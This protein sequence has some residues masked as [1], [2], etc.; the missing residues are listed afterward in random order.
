MTGPTK[1]YTRWLIGLIIFYLVAFSLFSV[2]KY[3]NF[4]YNALD[5]GIFNQVFFNSAQGRLFDFTIHPHSYLGDHLGFILVLL[6]PIYWLWQNPITLLILQT[7]FIG[8]TAWPIFLIAKKWLQPK[9]ALLISG[10]FLLSHFTH[11]INLF[12]FHLISL[13][14]PILFFLF[15]FYLTNKFTPF[16]IFTLLGL[17]VR[18]DVALIFIAFAILALVEKRKLKWKLFPSIAGL[19][20][21]FLSYQLT[22]YF[23]GYSSY[24]FL[25]YFAWLGDTP[26]QMLINFFANPLTTLAHLGS[27]G[28]IILIIGLFLP[29]LFIP[30]IKAKYLILSLPHLLIFILAGFNK[31]SNLST[32][33]LVFLTFGFWLAFI[34][35]LPY[36][37]KSKFVFWR[38]LGEEKILLTTV[39]LATTIYSAVF[40]GPAWSMIS[41]IAQNP[42]KAKIDVQRQ[43]INDISQD[44]SLLASY[45]TITNLSGRP[46]LYLNRYLFLNKQQYSDQAFPQPDNV[47]VAFFDSRDFLIYQLQYSDN[48]NYAGGHQRIRD[49]L[50]K[51]NLT[52]SEILDSFIVFKKNSNST[53]HPYQILDISEQI[54][55]K[56]EINIG[57]KIKL[58][59]FEINQPVDDILPVSFY[60]QA[61]Q[62]IEDEYDIFVEYLDADKK[63]IG[64]KLYAMAYGFLPTKDW[65]AQSVIQTNYWWQLPADQPND[66]KFITISLVTFEAH[67]GQSDILSG[68]IKDLTIDRLAPQI[69]FS[70]STGK[71]ESYR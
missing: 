64:N 3:N 13:A 4:Y 38:I 2:W 49:F 62:T 33:Y 47:D 27:P 10:L 28:N 71:L 32:H 48:D 1:K 14:L 65:P 70:I 11:S 22:T 44:S 37:A 15:Y 50:T 36:L 39:L 24:K 7:F 56:T 54:V 43:L 25:A 40:F 18:E 5:L 12:E 8:I 53:K 31:P 45:N 67:F 16:V 19:I 9:W 20:W 58:L 34:A 35:S 66:I 59:S 6:L 51:Q 30:L 46:N 29:F 26:G 57:N 17:A 68:E 52:P 23:T 42:D 69:T 55:Q 63:I 60:W 21:I 61:P 41:K